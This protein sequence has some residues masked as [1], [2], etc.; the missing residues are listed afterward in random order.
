MTPILLTPPTQKRTP[1]SIKASNVR[2]G[3]V[4]RKER[5]YEIQKKIWR[6]CNSLSQQKW[7]NKPMQVD[8]SIPLWKVEI[9]QHD[10]KVSQPRRYEYLAQMA[11]PTK[12]WVFFETLSKIHVLYK[13]MRILIHHT[14]CKDHG[15]CFLMLHCAWKGRLILWYIRYIIFNL[16][17]FEKCD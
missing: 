4:H 2:K 9:C 12:A 17:F 8:Y 15:I 6:C 11:A 16:F 1:R 5:S 7:Y 13:I 3:S 10:Y 14:S